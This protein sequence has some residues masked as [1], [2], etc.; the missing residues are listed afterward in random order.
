MAIKTNQH[1]LD[2][3]W[4]GIC[5]VEL[6]DHNISTPNSIINLSHVLQS[7][8]DVAN[9]VKI[10]QE[11]ARME[12]NIRNN[13]NELMYF[14]MTKKDQYREV[15][16]KKFQ[17]TYSKLTG[18]ENLSPFALLRILRSYRI[19]LLHEYCNQVLKDV[20]QDS[21]KI[22]TLDVCNQLREKAQLMP[23]NKKKLFHVSMGDV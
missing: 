14:I 9:P 2:G 21:I 8:S 20:Y 15:I 23:F 22:Q 13:S 16:A 12:S 1:F 3:P 18:I 11:K 4:R 7:N 6:L 17:S 5:E 10:A 19:K